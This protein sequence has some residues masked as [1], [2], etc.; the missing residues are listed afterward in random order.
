MLKGYETSMNHHILALFLNILALYL[1]A[2]FSL[3]IYPLELHPSQLQKCTLFL[4]K[5]KPEI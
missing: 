3:C 5:I 2:D 4:T 1:I